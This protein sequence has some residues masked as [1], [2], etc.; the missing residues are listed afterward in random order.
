MSDP[1]GIRP[2][3]PDDATALAAIYNP[4][5]EHSTSTFELRPV[6]P[7]IMAERLELVSRKH[8]WLVIEDE[9]GVGGYAYATAWRGRPAYENSVETTIYLA[10][11]RLGQGL[12]RRLYGA[13]VDALR[14]SGRHTAIGGIALP[15]DASIALHEALGYVEV[16]R[17]REVGFKFGRWIDVRYYEK[18]LGDPGDAP[19]PVRS[20]TDAIAR[21]GSGP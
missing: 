6:T 11:E 21:I 9:D 7:R 16:A 13:L 8:P 1:A 5:I 10:R 2:A 19:E 15:N 12:G 14:G 20:V 18:L 17:F 4:Y 3:R